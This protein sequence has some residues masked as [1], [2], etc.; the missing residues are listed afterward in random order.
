[1]PWKK[2]RK[3]RDPDW[4][5]APKETAALYLL[6]RQVYIDVVGSGLLYRFRKFYFSSP[7]T[8]LN[9]LWVINPRHKDAIRTIQLDIALVTY[10]GCFAADPART[11]GRPFEMLAGCQNLQHFTLNI[12]LHPKYYRMQYKPGNWNHWQHWSLRQT[13]VSMTVSNTVLDLVAGCASLK[14]IRG[15]KSFELLWTPTRSSLQNPVNPV[16][17]EKNNEV[18]ITQVVEEIRALITSKQQ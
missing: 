11:C 3:F 9:Y 7:T 5:N 10:L 15:L 2:G 14:R 17:F 12:K 4:K 8:M 1:M 18:R 16:P 13:P 6:S